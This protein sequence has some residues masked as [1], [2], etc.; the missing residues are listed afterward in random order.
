MPAITVYKNN[1][2]IDYE[3]VDQEYFIVEAPSSEL[4]WF[5]KDVHR[6]G[7]IKIWL[8]VREKKPLLCFVLPDWQLIIDG[9]WMERK[10]YQD[11]EGLGGKE[12]E[13]HYKEYRFVFQLK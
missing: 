12:V 10:F 8:Q 2:E 7:T 9:V 1:D 3:F 5:E 11:I 6:P 4:L 13:L